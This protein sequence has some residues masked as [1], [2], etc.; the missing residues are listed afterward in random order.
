MYRRR[1]FA[2][3]LVASLVACGG[4]GGS[5]P[6]PSGPNPA[7]PVTATAPAATATP[8]TVPQGTA[9]A[10]FSITVPKT[11]TSSSRRAPRYVPS[12]TQ[13][14]KF[15]LIKS[16]NGSA[17]TPSVSPVYP[18]TAATPGCTSGPN[19]LSCTIQITAPVG[20]NIY[21]ADVYGTT[22]G[23]GPKFGSGSVKLTVLDNAVNSASLTLSGAIASVVLSTDDVANGA[24][25]SQIEYISL[26]NGYHL[27]WPPNSLVPQSARIFVVALDSQGNQII[28]PD[29][30]STPVTLTMAY[31]TPPSSPAG[32]SRGTSSVAPPPQAFANLAVTYSFPQN[33]VLADTT[34]PSKNTVLVQ[35]PADK[36]VITPF[37]ASNPVYITIT[38]TVNGTVQARQ[39][40][41]GIVRNQCPPGYTGSA[42]DNCIAPTPV[43]LP[44]AWQNPNAYGSFTGDGSGNATFEA[45]FDPNQSFLGYTFRIATNGVAKQVTVDASAC[46]PIVA[47]VVAPPNPSPSP[48]PDPNATPTPPATP[49]PTPVPSGSPSALPTGTTLSLRPKVFVPTAT[50]SPSPTPNPASY[51]VTTNTADPTYTI[52]VPS[53]PGVGRCVIR[54]TDTSSHE[55][56]MTFSITQSSLIIQGGKRR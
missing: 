38:A 1:F 41:Y 53:N 50:P 8:G 28:S 21:V 19:G 49:S 30:F 27:Q 51:I 52:Y 48:S 10:T 3:G 46:Y 42:P 29:T 4:G 35:S 24:N 56:D 40:Y 5:S 11:S 55:V 37:S 6:A 14:I 32:S 47:A 45:G 15:T 16:D 12:G 17:V 26:L 39:L 33:N 44:L 23:S 34:T 54:A 2:L 18:L 13:S 31:F 43:P 25:L 7:S 36:T 20:T 22:D 9:R